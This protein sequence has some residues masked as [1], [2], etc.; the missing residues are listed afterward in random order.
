M[1][2]SISGTGSEVLRSCSV[3]HECRL[4]YFASIGGYDWLHPTLLLVAMIGSIRSLLLD[5]MIGLHPHT[6][7][8]HRLDVRIVVAA[9]RR[10]RVNEHGEQ[11]VDVRARGSGALCVCVEGGGRK[12]RSKKGHVGGERNDEWMGKY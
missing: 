9:H 4:I 5:A 10:T 2:K 7:L 6:C 8:R 3:K 12:M 1:V 11:L